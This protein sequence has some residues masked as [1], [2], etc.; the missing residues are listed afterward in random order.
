MNKYEF[1]GETKFWLGRTLRQIR[2]KISFGIV[3]AGEVGG[4]IEKEGNLSDDGNAR[5]Y[6]NAQVYGDAQVYKQS[7]FLCI[8]PI[9]SRFDFTTFF[10]TKNS[11]IYVK[12]GCFRG[13]IQE[14]AEKVSKTHYDSIYAK[15]YMAAIVAAKACIDLTRE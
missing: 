3:K 14:F 11:E 6:G 15:Q 4:W 8:G 2:E 1:T 10:R 5:V 12:C 7:H 13:N 9:G